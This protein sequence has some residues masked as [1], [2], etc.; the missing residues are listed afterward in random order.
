MKIKISKSE[1]A[2]NKKPFMMQRQELT[3]MVIFKNVL[4]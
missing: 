2:D 1:I 3:M 4:N